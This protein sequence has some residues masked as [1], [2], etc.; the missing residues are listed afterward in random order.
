MRRSAPVLVALGAAA[1]LLLLYGLLGGGRYAPTPVAD[2]CAARDRSPADGITVA[3][4]QVVLATVDGAACELGVSREE[5][6][7]ALRDRDT[8]EQLAARQ[9]VS[10][11]DAERTLATSLERAVDDAEA[12]GA[13]PGF[14]AGVVRNVAENVPAWLLFD[15]LDRLRSLVS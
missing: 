13:L 15:V 4:E 11:S 12:T 9:G 14:V 8:L 6:V 3:L 5:L 2:P 10:R 7:L 1:A